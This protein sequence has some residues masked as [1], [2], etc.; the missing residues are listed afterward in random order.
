MA[1]LTKAIEINPGHPYAFNNR[2]WIYVKQ[3]KYQDAIT[4]LD[5]ALSISE[6]AT[7]YDTRGWAFFFLERLEE[8]HQDAISALE[9]DSEAYNARALLYR[10]EVKKGKAEEA[11]TSLKNYLSKYEGTEIKDPY[12][13]ILRYFA[14][15]VAL[16]HLR[17]NP[18]WED[19]KV[20]L[21][22][23]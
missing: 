6:E 21:R 20:A 16:E 4:D 1:D 13:L 23:Y 10:V 11:V 15:E 22:H 18:H 2:G 14:N 9:L 3:E 8:A 7:F 5:K 17:N 12:F 19:L